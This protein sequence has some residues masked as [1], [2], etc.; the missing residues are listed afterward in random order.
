MIK[1]KPFVNDN[2]EQQSTD[3]SMFSNL[4]MYIYNIWIL[5]RMVTSI[6]PE[7]NKNRSAKYLDEYCIEIQINSL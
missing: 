4:Q 1:S 5:R 6:I 2:S 7:K 3:S